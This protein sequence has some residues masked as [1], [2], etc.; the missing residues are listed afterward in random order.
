MTD[1]LLLVEV[2]GVLWPRLPRRK[3]IELSDWAMETER[4]TTSAKRWTRLG[5][6]IAGV[7]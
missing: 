6:R 7:E 5:E 1:D 2:D 4:R 3:R